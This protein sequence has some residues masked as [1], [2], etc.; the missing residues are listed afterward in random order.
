MRGIL[1]GNY[2]HC[3]APRSPEAS[4]TQ[5][6]AVSASFSVASHSGTLRVDGRS[7]AS[8]WSASA[9][10]SSTLTSAMGEPRSAVI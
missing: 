10:I 4:P 1:G 5:H 6:F 9:L 8:T 3:A 7:A 2:V